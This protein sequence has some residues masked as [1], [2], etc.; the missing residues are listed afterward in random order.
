MDILWALAG[1]AVGMINFG[2]VIFIVDRIVHDKHQVRAY[3]P[4]LAKEIR[5][6]AL[7]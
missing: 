6:H 5:E 2:Y 4:P 7:A 1:L 3:T